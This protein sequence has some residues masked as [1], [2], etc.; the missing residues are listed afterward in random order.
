MG[1]TDASDD[2]SELQEAV[3]A[4]LTVPRTAAELA[5]LV[6]DGEA[7]TGA[8][9]G[10]ISR[11][12]RKHNERVVD[13]DPEGFYYWAGAEEVLH[14]LS[15]EAKQTKTRRVNKYRMEKERQIKQV[16]Q[17]TQP[18]V[19]PQNPDPSH[20]DIVWFFTDLHY[21]D[22]VVDPRT[23]DVLYNF[24]IIDQRVEQMVHEGLQHYRRAQAHTEFDTAHLVLGG[25]LCTG[26]VV[27]DSQW[28]D[29]EGT[30]DEQTDRARDKLWWAIA[31]LAEE[32][33]TVQVVVV[34]GNHG[35]RRSSAASGN[36][37]TD[38]QLFGDLDLAARVSPYDNIHMVRN[39]TNAGFLNFDM[40]DGAIKA[41]LRHGDDCSKHVDA[42]SKSSKDWRG[43]LRVHDFDIALK[44]HI[45]VLQSEMAM[46]I[47][48]ITGG[49]PK[50][51]DEF[52]ESIGEWGAPQAVVFG[53]SDDH[54]PT[55]TR[56]V[57]FG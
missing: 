3:I 22:E 44:G 40:R 21:G 28:V 32:F 10:L 45:H 55:W 43:W 1:T 17:A 35:A 13:F 41:H 8:I 50:P 7:T 57:Y 11:I 24:D 14:Q 15:S 42:T 25:D 33:D 18:A 20:E 5:D 52:V 6:Y 39:K 30:L 23:G 36:A 12:N 26:E 56:P 38:I 54:A 16:L 51:P 9:R 47:P 27:Y 4:H 31:T 53:V 49:A 46:D 37:N 29:I 2:Y 19:A 48:V 34:P